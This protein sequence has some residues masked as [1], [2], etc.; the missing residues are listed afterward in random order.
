IDQATSLGADFF[1]TIVPAVVRLPNS[2]ETTSTV[3]DDGEVVSATL[4]TTTR[5]AE[6]SRSLMKAFPEAATNTIKGR[7][8]EFCKKLNGDAALHE[9][10]P[11]SLSDDD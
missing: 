4:G 6:L 1:L 2:P 7:I 5:R 3:F 8:V 11:E 9:L 10:D